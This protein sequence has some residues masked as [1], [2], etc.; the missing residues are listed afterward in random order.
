MKQFEALYING[1]LVNIGSS[2]ITLEWKSVMLSNISKLKVNHSY[3]IKLPMTANN[4]KVF[5]NAE[6]AAHDAYLQTNNAAMPYGRRMS[7]RYYC[8]G[9]DLLGAANAYLIGTDKSYYK[10]VLTWGSLSLLEAV[11]SED[12][13]LP[14][15]F[16]NI[17]TRPTQIDW[18]KW[19]EEKISDALGD[20]VVHIPY[21]KTEHGDITMPYICELPSFKVTW[22]IDRIM[23]K[24]GVKYDFTKTYT[25]DGQEVSKNEELLDSLYCPMVSLNDSKYVQNYNHAKFYPTQVE[26]KNNEWT[27][28]YATQPIFLERVS[29]VYPDGQSTPVIGWCGSHQMMKYKMKVHLRVFVF[30]YQRLDGNAWIQQNVKLSVVNGQGENAS[31]VASF[32]PTSIRVIGIYWPSLYSGV[33]TCYEVLYEYTEDW[34]EVDANDTPGGDYWKEWTYDQALIERQK[35]SLR[36]THPQAVLDVS[37]V[38]FFLWDL[39][40]TI[41]QTWSNWVDICPLI[42]TGKAWNDTYAAITTVDEPTPLYLEPNFPDLKPIDFLKAIFYMIGAFPVV[43]GDT[44]KLT[45]YSELVANVSKA[46]DWSRFVIDD[47]NIPDTI[48]FEL[49]EWA[50]KNWM[51]YKDDD[52]ENPKYSGFFEIDDDYLEEEDDIFTLPFRGCQTHG[53]VAIPIWENGKVLRQVAYSIA[54]GTVEEIEGWVFKEQKPYILHRS[55]VDYPEMVWNDI[56]IPAGRVSSFDFSSLSLADENSLIRQRYNVFAELLRHP[57][58]ITVTMDLD[59]FTLSDLDLG[60]PVFLRQ[61][62]SYFAIINIKRKS[63]GKCTVKLLRI[64]NKLITG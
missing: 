6:D 31:Q 20:N 15:I 5:D 28:L 61:H 7:A 2:D 14:D 40:S 54:G 53:G 23:K 13:T 19:T 16:D 4:R 9:V 58:V 22:I 47:D 57:Y 24:Y 51:R 10:V 34:E 37:S 44:L 21:I 35:R 11:I 26:S 63:D 27:N 18:R 45:L 25:V 59:E 12:R 50:K 55:T 33:Q 32:E 46:L 36:I 56:I 64:P 52:E 38:Q 42:T 48:D 29:S 3:T 60:V 1:Q 17:E 30:D 8:N 41:D 49:T 43:K 39:K 62:S